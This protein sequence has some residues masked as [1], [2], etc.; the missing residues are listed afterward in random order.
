MEA[1]YGGKE[2]G[3][4][5]AGFGVSIMVLNGLEANLDESNGAIKRR[6]GHYLDITSK[7]GVDVT[8]E[9]LNTLGMQPF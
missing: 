6:I 7:M 1:R 9:K 5:S 4:G 8:G 2:K 3:L